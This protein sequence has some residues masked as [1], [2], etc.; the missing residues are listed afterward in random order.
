MT[1]GFADKGGGGSREERLLRIAKSRTCERIFASVSRE[2]FKLLVPIYGSRGNFVCQHDELGS[3][4][5]GDGDSYS[6]CVGGKNKREK[7]GDKEKNVAQL[8]EIAVSETRVEFEEEGGLVAALRSF[9]ATALKKFAGRSV[10]GFLAI[11]NCAAGSRDCFSCRSRRVARLI[12]LAELDVVKNCKIG[13]S[14]LLLSSGRSSG[15]PSRHRPR[16]CGGR[17]VLP[18]TKREL[19]FHSEDDDEDKDAD[20]KK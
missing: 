16:C 5:A 10:A 6:N 19:F 2:L 18:T 9:V 20:L 14:E 15:G 3:V 4:S 12:L 17:H 13:C 11:R 7:F 1:F 8:L